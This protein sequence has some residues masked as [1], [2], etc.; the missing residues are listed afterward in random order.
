M[1]EVG[2]RL[3]SAVQQ[4]VARLETILI[5]GPNME[6]VALHLLARNGGVSESALIDNHPYMFARGRENIEACEAIA[7]RV[8][9]TDPALAEWIRAL[10][11]DRACAMCEGSGRLFDE[12]TGS[13]VDC[14]CKTGRA[15]DGVGSAIARA[16]SRVVADPVGQ[17]A[18]DAALRLGTM[19]AR[20]ALESIV[21]QHKVALKRWTVDQLTFALFVLAEASGAARPWTLLKNRGDRGPRVAV[22]VDD[23]ATRDRDAGGW[24]ALWAERVPCAK[25]EGQSCRRCY[26]TGLEVEAHR[27]E[28]QAALRRIS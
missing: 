16:L 23:V 19:T 25:C 9:R 4:A 2:D 24:L 14:V 20:W 7:D 13:H 27:R 11:Y 18:I 5:I 22:V 8:E 1:T 21:V 6:A 12:R 28:I 10:I 17:L 15:I 26:Q 3:E